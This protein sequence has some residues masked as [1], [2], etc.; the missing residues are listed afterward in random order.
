MQKDKGL[1]PHLP[2]ESEKAELIKGA[3]GLEIVKG[4]GGKAF[5]QKDGVSFLLHNK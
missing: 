1:W 4:D 5:N 3:Y 2:L